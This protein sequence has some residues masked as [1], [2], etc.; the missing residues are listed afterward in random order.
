MFCFFPGILLEASRRHTDIDRVGSL[1][2]LIN[3]E[4]RERA[5]SLIAPVR[6]VAVGVMVSIFV[7]RRKNN[8]S[9]VGGGEGR[10]LAKCATVFV[11]LH[12]KKEARSE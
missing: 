10:R 1:R 5:L 11:H 7:K 9:T 6:G 2:R 4:Q 12:L 8:S 3:F